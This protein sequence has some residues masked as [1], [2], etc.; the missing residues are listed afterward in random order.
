MLKLVLC[1]F[2]QYKYWHPSVSFDYPFL[3]LILV[4]LI[5]SLEFQQTYLPKAFISL[6]EHRGHW[7]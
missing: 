6:T 3:I 4:G 2:S 1:I 5:G 7:T